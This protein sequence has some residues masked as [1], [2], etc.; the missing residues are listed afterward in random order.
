MS[1]AKFAKGPEFKKDH[2]LLINRY[3][4]KP[5][6]YLIQMTEVCFLTRTLEH[7]EITED[8]IP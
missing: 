6:S 4:I 8:N 3:Y 5:I 1:E 7:S 2:L